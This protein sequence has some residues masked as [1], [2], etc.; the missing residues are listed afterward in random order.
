M[1]TADVLEGDIFASIQDAFGR[2]PAAVDAYARREVRPFVSQMVDK[3]LRVEPPVR[4]WPADYPEGKLEWTSEKQRRY[5]HAVILEHDEDGNV[6]PY[7]RTHDFV[8]GWHVRADYTNGL[9]AI[10]IFHEDDVMQFITG[11]RQQR[12]HRITGWPYAPDVMQVIELETAEFVNQGLP[13]VLDQ[14]M[15]GKVS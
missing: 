4:D 13:S 3:H 8:H 14:A 11:L 10:R 7:E 9:T 12:F 15:S 6:I 1:L 2:F 5:V